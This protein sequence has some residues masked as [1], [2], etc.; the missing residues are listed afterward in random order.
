[1]SLQQIQF[2]KKLTGENFCD[3]IYT[4]IMNKVD[5]FKYTVYT[6]NTY[7]FFKSQA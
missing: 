1:M 7:V 3:T 2:G 5:K 4:Y 6:R